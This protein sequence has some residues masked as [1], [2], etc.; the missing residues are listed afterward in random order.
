[1]HVKYTLR[2]FLACTLL[3]LCGSGLGP[4]AAQAPAC[5]NAC[6]KSFVDGYFDALPSGILEATLA[7]QEKYTENG[8]VLELGQGFWHTA[9]APLG[10]A[11]TCWN[12][13]QA[14]RP[15]SPVAGYDGIAQ[16]SGA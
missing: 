4:A 2:S 6:S 11:I 12:P 3:S 8:R 10:I 7:A 9:G 1:M 5:D 15:H 14:A 13:K 16:M